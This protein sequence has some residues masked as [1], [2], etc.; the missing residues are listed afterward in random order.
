MSAQ[1]RAGGVL[2]GKLA[3]EGEP[4]PWEPMLVNVD[5]N[6]S[7][8]N[9]TQAD[10]RGQF[11]ITF[12]DT[13]GVER[14][15]A[16]AQRQMETKYEGCIVR[17]SL[18]GFRSS[19]VT[20]TVHHLRDEP[21]LGTITLSPDARG[22]GTELSATSKAAPSNAMKAFEKARAEYL[23]G[24]TGSAQHNLK[25]AVDLYPGFAQAWLQLGKIQETSDP[26]GARDSFSKALTA[27]PKFVLPYEQLAR[28][29]AQAEKWQET[30]DNTNQGLQLDSMGTPQLWYYDS[31]AKFQLGRT[32]EARVSAAKS[33]AIDPRHSVQSTEQLLA[34]ILARKADYTGAIQHLQNCLTYLPAGPQADMVKQQIAQIAR[35]VPASK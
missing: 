35:K 11:V 18:T 20:I 14:I 15:P 27:D 17:G 25:K 13:H 34:V 33:M 10:L 22:G 26:Q 16:D 28:L 24:D 32:E 6:G 7:V 5:C 30:L 4:L 2:L 8:V 9:S 3:L 1:G 12:V 21:N 29:A 19:A 31:L 23:D